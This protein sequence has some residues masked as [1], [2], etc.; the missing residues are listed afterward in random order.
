MKSKLESGKQ[1][2]L[3][4]LFC[5]ERR[6]IIPDLQRDYCWGDQTHGSGKIE[7]VTD[8]VSSLI[9]L[10][11]NLGNRNYQLGMIYA[12]E[13]PINHIHL[14]DGQQRITTLY[15]LL[16]ML[17]KHIG[18]NEGKNIQNFLMSD[19][20][21][22]DDKEPHLQ[23]AIRESTLYFLSDLVYEFFFM[24]DLKVEDIRKTKWYFAD[25][26]LD[27]TI[28]SMLNAL[29]IIED[30]I[31]H[32]TNHNEFANF[33]LHNV[34]FFYFDMGNRQHGE[35][36]F[37]VINTTGEPLT[38]T[39]N[40]KP[41]LVGAGGENNHQNEAGDIWEKW[42]KWFWL[43]RME[44]EHEADAGLN[45]FLIWYW[46]AK[47]KQ[48]SDWSKG[49]KENLKPIKLF[50]EKPARINHDEYTEYSAINENDWKKAKSITEVDKYFEQYCILNSYT[51]DNDFKNVLDFKKDNLISLR[52]FNINQ[53][54][55]IIVPM[56][57]FMVRFPNKTEEHLKFFR[58]LRKNH[59]DGEWEDRKHNYVDWRHILEIIERCEVPESVFRYEGSLD[60]FK[61]IPNIKNN[62]YN[63][64]NDEEKRKEKLK[65]NYNEKIEMW[66]D[67]QDL[68]GD[69]S[70]LF[71]VDE[72][73]DSSIPIEILRLEKYYE[74]YTNTIDLV[75]NKYCGD[76]EEKRKLSNLFRLFR[77]YSGCSKVGHIPRVSW[78][79]EGVLF[80]NI[81]NREHFKNIEF[82][83]LCAADNQVKFCENY[84]IEKLTEWNLF[85]LTEENYSTDRFIKVWLTLKVFNAIKEKSLLPYYE[86]NGT[87]VAAYIRASWNV[88]VREA[89]FSMQNSM[90][91]FAVKSGRGGESYIHYSGEQDWQKP[92]M[93]GS[94]FKG[95]ERSEDNRNASGLYK[96]KQH[97]DHIIEFIH[98]YE[99]AAIDF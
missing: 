79:I 8:F 46:Q 60:N 11:E 54:Q 64:Y 39:E 56:I 87:G 65:I 61:R 74:N 77:L 33:L 48:E 57:E 94:P 34:K 25:Y 95:I 40:L 76:E 72:I 47:L 89:P 52:H 92:D 9:E 96:N 53:A 19:F 98:N 73:A 27:P 1:Y 75:R 13:N 35:E 42:E 88:L 14:C 71:D 30:I 20:E 68:M 17:Y 80:S 15:L 26:D 62:V 12:Y 51:K 82:K 81:N 7:L 85:N 97:I 55:D 36:M 24:D 99:F 32:R 2:S 23:Y 21:R 4:D 16:G 5:E 45:Q 44:R 37:V 28:Q 49:R 22:T 67:H 10:F 41:I 90:C 38:P 29:A 84:I 58:R 50:K 70:F 93:I 83:K 3:S 66:E 63:W 59:Y 86:G 31:K 91:G 6:I 43:N 78:E 18:D 69:L